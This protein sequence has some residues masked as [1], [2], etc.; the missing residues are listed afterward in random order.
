[1]PGVAIVIE[2]AVFLEAGHDYADEELVLGAAGEFLLHFVDGVGATHEGAEGYV[3][4]FVF[5]VE[6][7]GAGEHAGENEVRM[8][9]SKEAGKR[10]RRKQPMAFMVRLG[11][12]H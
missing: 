8:E 10:D 2:L 6:F 11:G 3:V 1:M 12:A 5:G 4:E 9:R 7:A